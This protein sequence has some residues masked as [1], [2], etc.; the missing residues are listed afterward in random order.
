MTT[1]GLKREKLINNY[2]KRKM[3][4]KLSL[5][6]IA[7]AGLFAQAQNSEVCTENLSLMATSVKSKNIDAYD[8]LALLRKDCPSFHKS[9]YS[10]G[11]AAIKLRI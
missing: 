8:Y 11:E 1:A 7:I 3:K 5:L 9:I 2:S 10:Y 6:L 4:T